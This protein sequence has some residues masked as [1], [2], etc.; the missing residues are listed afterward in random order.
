MSRFIVLLLC[1]FQIIY[2]LS[3]QSFQSEE[4]CTQVVTEQQRQQSS[5]SNNNLSDL[6]IQAMQRGLWSCA[7][8]I[9]QISSEAKQFTFRTAFDVQYRLI[10]SE[11]TSLKATVDSYL[12]T[13]IV[14]PAFQW[15][16]S[17]TDIMLNVKF[18]HKI[19][20]PATLN[21]EA[22]NITI[23]SDKLS[24][25]ATDGRKIFKL[26]LDFLKDILPD[27]SRYEMAS[28]GRM[29]FTFKKAGSPSKWSRLLKQTDSKLTPSNMHKWFSMQEKY[30]AELTK[31]D[32]NTTSS[33]V[34]NATDSESASSSSSSSSSSDAKKK[35]KA[36]AAKK[37]SKTP[38][39]KEANNKDDDDDDEDST[40][41]SSE[42][43]SDHP[44]YDRIEALKKTKADELQALQE[45]AMTQKKTLDV[46]WREDKKRVDEMTSSRKKLIESRIQEEIESLISQTG[47]IQ[48]ESVSSTGGVD[49]DGGEL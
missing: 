39:K 24:L 23:L 2:S 35:G 31:L 27:D 20:A 33:N 32:D 14:S 18:S 41:K 15:A 17:T 5:S 10:L 29:T 21:V 8:N 37:K 34:T 30:D 40:K 3:A 44:N 36:A 46:K 38:K 45:E 9:V 13:P 47:S 42:I 43:S 16:Q 22:T 25:E 28:V 7:K 11:L 1:L 12:S 26:E 6:L 4:Q 48:P 49:V 19:D